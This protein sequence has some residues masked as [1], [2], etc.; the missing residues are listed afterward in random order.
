MFQKIKESKALRYTLFGILLYL[1]VLA[2]CHVEAAKGLGDDPGETI[3]PV[4]YAI[5]TGLM[6]I[7]F[8]KTQDRRRKITAGIGGVLLAFSYVFGVYLHYQN[9]LFVSAGQVLFIFLVVAGVSLTTV[10]L[11][12][13][14]FEVIDKA[15]DW[16]ASKKEHPTGSVKPKGLFLR[17]WIG[18]FACYIPVF[19]AFWPVNFVYDAQYQLSEVINNQYKVHHPLLHTWL[20]GVCYKLGGRW[21]DSVSVGISFYTIIQM[22]LC[23]AAFAY[24]LWYLYRKGVP[25][26]FRVLTFVF[27]AIFPINS[28]FAISATKDVLFAAFFITFFITLMQVCEDKV[29]IKVPIMILMV[30]SGILTILFRKNAI[31]AVVAAIPFLIWATA[32]KMRKVIITVTLLAIVLLSELADDG[33]IKILDAKGNSTTR[34]SCS[35]MVQPLA[36]VACYRKDELDPALYDEMVMYWW[37]G[38]EEPYNP[39]LS[40]AIKNDVNVPFLEANYSNFLKLFVKVGLQFPGEYAESILTNTMGY[41][42]MGDLAHHMAA[43][44]RISL[45]HTLIGEGEEIVKQNYCNIVNKIY[46]PLFVYRSC[47]ETPILAWL[48]RSSTYFWLLAVYVLYVIY[49]KEPRKLLLPS[50][51]ILYFGTCFLGPWVALR[52][53]YTVVV[54]TPLII[55]RLFTSRCPDENAKT[56]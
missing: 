40:D 47:E 16:F 24:C 52:Y 1:N 22:L 31:Y 38:F 33:L 15:R 36:R 21:F 14:F 44:D 48:F 2:I 7:R 30:L 37:E 3:A 19:L 12:T 23:S 46:E 17:Y 43:G 10:P 41:W 11:F 56:L 54:V 6:L 8:L 51:Y 32:E 4:F 35:A 18:I 27:Y 28:L 13:L 26:V 29:T 34:E 49:K 39:Y 5:A 53:I 20:M 45:Y 9:D 50:L 55:Y 42:Y 25:K